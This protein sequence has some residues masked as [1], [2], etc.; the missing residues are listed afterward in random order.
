[1]PEDAE[2]LGNYKGVMLCNRPGAEQVAESSSKPFVPVGHHEPVGVPPPYNK[3]ATIVDRQWASSPRAAKPKNKIYENHK[4]WLKSLEKRGKEVEEERISNELSAEEKKVRLKALADKYRTDVR[5]MMNQATDEKKKSAKKRSIPL[6]VKE[7]WDKRIFEEAVNLTRTTQQTEGDS[8]DEPGNKVPPIEPAEDPEEL[9]DFASSLDFE[10]FV[11]DLEFREALSVL[12]DRAKKLER[13]EKLFQ[14][15]VAE[16]LAEEG[17]TGD[18]APNLFFSEEPNAVLSKE[19]RRLMKIL[20]KKEKY[21]ARMPAGLVEKYW[22]EVVPDEEQ[23]DEVETATDVSQLVDDVMP[24]LKAIHSKASA[25]KAV[26]T[27]VEG[28]E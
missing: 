28:K 20:A 24:K 8:K 18:R 4:D 7:R 13:E 9:L 27:A 3:G 14:M 5:A 19:D 17:Y 16:M 10:Q 15:N 22:G 6:W 12:R 25:T 11:D 23:E 2:G 1:M 26:T 21:R